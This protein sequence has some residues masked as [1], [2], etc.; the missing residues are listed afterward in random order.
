MD[1]KMVRLSDMHEGQQLCSVRSTYLRICSNHGF[2]APARNP[3]ASSDIIFLG[4]A[5]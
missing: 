1:L 4:L 5:C 2:L 3:R